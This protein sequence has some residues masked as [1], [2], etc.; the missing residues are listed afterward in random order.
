MNQPVSGKKKGNQPH[1]TR[2]FSPNHVLTYYPDIQIG[3]RINS[4]ASLLI[5]IHV[6]TFDHAALGILVPSTYGQYMVRIDSDRVIGGSRQVFADLQ[7]TYLYACESNFV[8]TSHSRAF[9][10]GCIRLPS[11][12]STVLPESGASWT[13]S[14]IS[15]ICQ[16]MCLAARSLIIMPCYGVMRFP[17]QNRIVLFPP[18]NFSSFLSRSK[19]I[20]VPTLSGNGVKEMELMSLSLHG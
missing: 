20:S 13:R 10:R 5:Y 4:M 14:G 18:L 11:R 19:S 2:A 3:F 16:E 9:S 15:E 7:A 8:S 6:L 17:Q 1:S 12:L